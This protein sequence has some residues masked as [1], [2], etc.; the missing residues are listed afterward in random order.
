MC[1]IFDDS[2]Q[3]WRWWAHWLH[4]QHHGLLRSI[5]PPSSMRTRHKQLFTVR[6]HSELTVWS[7]VRALYKVYIF[8]IVLSFSFSESWKSDIPP[9]G[10]LPISQPTAQPPQYPDHLNLPYLSLPTTIPAGFLSCIADNC[11]G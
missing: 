4:T 7:T 10:Q 5:A 1:D 9:L 11:L 2:E 3:Y 8:R 6:S